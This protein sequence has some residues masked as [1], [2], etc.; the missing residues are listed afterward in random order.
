[1]PVLAVILWEW[2]GIGVGCWLS[3]GNLPPIS[4]GRSNAMS[5]VR[6]DVASC[7]QA[8]GCSVALDRGAPNLNNELEA[9]FCGDASYLPLGG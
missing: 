1:M 6:P 8:L 3:R 9:F 2:N 5:V 4:E 7:I